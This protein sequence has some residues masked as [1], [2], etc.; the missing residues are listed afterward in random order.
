MQYC[1]QEQLKSKQDGLQ[2]EMHQ[3]EMKIQEVKQASVSHKVSVTQYIYRNQCW[4]H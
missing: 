4:L 1:S 2:E 3:T